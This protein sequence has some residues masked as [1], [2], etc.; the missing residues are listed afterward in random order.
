M[1]IFWL[2]MIFNK[3]NQV[4]PSSSF[5]SVVADDLVLTWTCLARRG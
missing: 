2:K 3:P 4:F 5:A 1:A